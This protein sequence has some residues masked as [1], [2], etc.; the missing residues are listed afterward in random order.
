M[1]NHW[2]GWFISEIVTHWL[3]PTAIDAGMDHKLLQNPL[4]FLPPPCFLLPASLRFS[5]FV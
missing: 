5:N 1:K 3:K 4:A 2:L